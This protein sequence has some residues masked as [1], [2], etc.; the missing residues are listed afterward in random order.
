MKIVVLDGYTANPGDISWEPVSSL[1]DFTVYDRTEPE[2]IVSR[3]IDAEIVIINKTVLTADILQ[4]LPN[5]K[6][7]SLLSTGTNAVDLVAARKLGIT[8]SNAPGYSTPT[9][10]QMTFSL[11]CELAF[12]AGLHSEDV[13][14]DG[15]VNSE[16]FCYW[17]KPLIEFAGKTLGII[18]YGSIGRN[19]ARIGEAFGMNVIIH[20]R[21]KPDDILPAQW[22][23]FDE[24]L[25]E[26]DFLTLHCPLTDSNKEFIDKEALSKIKSSAYLI[27]TARGGLVNEK[28][29]A[30]AL[31]TGKIAGAGLDVLSTEPPKADNPLLKAKNCVITPHIAWAS[32]DARKRLMEIEAGNIKGYLSGNLQNVVN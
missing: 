26:A 6:F 20:S 18:G 10:A 30:E 1:G 8:V 3:A 4:K 15:W 14:N 32:I 19:V 28:D 17:K 27:N 12:G 13:H 25:A 11:M 21:T 2:D 7:V 22:R 31:N 16:D 5:L 24:I 29:L 9:V 23:S